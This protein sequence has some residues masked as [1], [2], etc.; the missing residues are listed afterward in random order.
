[1]LPQ[2]DDTRFDLLK[3]EVPWREITLAVGLMLFGLLSFIMAWMHVTQE[4][5][6]KEKAVRLCTFPLSCC[7]QHWQTLRGPARGNSDSGCACADMHACAVCAE[8]HAWRMHAH[9]ALEVSS[10]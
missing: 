7:A 2:R 10:T 5:L 8:R 6:G 1:M 4:I 3:A 9:A